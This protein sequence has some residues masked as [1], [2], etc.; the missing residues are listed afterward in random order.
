MFTCICFC[1]A[2]LGVE[3][4]KLE[5]GVI[6]IIFFTSSLTLQANKIVD[7]NKLFLL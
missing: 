1:V 5:S 4:L 6:V 2:V 7:L 3:A